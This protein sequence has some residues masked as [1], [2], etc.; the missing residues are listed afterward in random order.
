V[1]RSEARKGDPA[2]ITIEQDAHLSRC[3]KRD[4]KKEADFIDAVKKT[5][6]CVRSRRW[7]C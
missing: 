5:K 4:Y 3:N 6:G 1:S 7:R 2:T